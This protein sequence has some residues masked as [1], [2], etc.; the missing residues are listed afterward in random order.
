[1]DKWIVLGIE[2]TKDKDQ[3]KKAY[4]RKLS[5]VNPEDDQEGFMELRKAYD[6]AMYEAD[7]EEDDACKEVIEEGTLLYEFTTLY[8][9]FYLRID[10]EQWKKLFERDEFM[11]LDSS[12]DSM[13]ELLR[14]MMSKN[15]LPHKVFKLIVN[16]FD[17]VEKRDELLE[18]FPPNYIDFVINN[19][20]YEDYIDYQLFERVDDKVDQYID[21]YYYF[22]TAVSRGDIEAEAKYLDILEGL[23]T[24]HPYAEIGRIR[25]EIRKMNKTVEN[26]EERATKYNKELEE[27]YAR[28]TKVLNRYPDNTF[29]IVACGD[30]A[31]ARAM[32]D[33]GEEYFNKALAADEN[34]YSI[35]SRLGDLY[36]LRGENEKARDLFMALLDINNYNDGV[37][38]G[39]YRAN[40]ALIEEYKKQVELDTENQE[41]KLKL[42]WCYYRIHSP[43][44][45]IEVLETF[46][47]TEKN[48]CEYYDLL[49]RAYLYSERYD[50]AV[51]AFIKWVDAIKGIS[52]DDE[53]EKAVE[54]RSRYNYANYYVG[55]AY[56]RLKEYDKAREYL[57]IAI[58]KEHKYIEYA[59]EAMGELEYECGNYNECIKVCESLLDSNINYD[60]YMY[61]AKSNY[62]L[63]NLG[64]AIDAC[65]S[66][67]RIH[68]YYY[69]PYVLMLRIYWECQAYEE[70]L[71]VV[72]RFDR[73]GYELDDVEYYKARLLAN[74]NKYQEAYQKLV[75]IVEKK[76]TEEASI[77]DRDYLDVYAFAAYVCEQLDEEEKALDYLY[78]GLGEEP[79]DP[80]FTYRIADV[81]HVLHQFE[82]TVQ[83]YDII[84]DISSD[85]S[86]RR[87][88][89]RGK[90]AAYCC[91][92]KFDEA[93]KVFEQ[94][95][96]EFGLSGWNI[97]DHAEL[98][99]R[100]NNL[101]GAVALLRKCI[102]ELEYSDF[103][104]SCIG[105]L[106][107][108][109]GNEGYL[110]EAYEMFLLGNEKDPEDYHLYRS[111]GYVYLDHKM[112]DKA[113]EFFLKA[114]EMDEAKDCYTAGLYLLAVAATDDV[115]KPEYEKYIELGLSQFEGANSAYVYNKM[116]EFYRA[117]GEYDKAIQCARDAIACKLDKLNC[118]YDSA[119]AYYELGNIYMDMG[120]YADAVDN[121]EAAL[122]IFGHHKQFEDCLKVAEKKLEES[123]Q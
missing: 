117:I 110:D 108:F 119:D 51:D 112:Y 85:E 83:Y 72:E 17:I 5:S 120:M 30:I 47:P 58:E 65:E 104:Q 45:A 96:E 23:Y 70:V 44:E 84:L 9:D 97:I 8:N 94:C 81:C 61:I 21:A 114:I 37:R 33:E 27:L 11:A 105:N 82:K 54:N 66:A 25:H 67:I 92:M 42:V 12:W 107:C 50:M 86:Y 95:E 29:I 123:N 57:N 31:V 102:N 77:K 111:M 60:A 18:L 32:Y 40:Q 26:L 76:D 3:I 15:Y 63:D 36:L 13:V 78:K 115:H 101:D 71:A 20:T 74:D 41:L 64:A 121:Y 113:K 1:M 14:F 52:E 116:V 7:K 59:Y 28:A 79:G 90:A 106:C 91:M 109:Y 35:K 55:L 48:R 118:F 75:R 16:T 88:A 24:V 56:I 4:R 10:I 49:G 34:N 93:N 43:K 68:E 122:A 62:R 73:L 100:M 39:F 87:R 80:F 99:V 38:Y 103:V 53:S 2:K 22:N 19:A 6:D 89:Y 46:S 69:D 98:M